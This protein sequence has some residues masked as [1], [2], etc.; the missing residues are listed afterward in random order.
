MK[1]ILDLIVV[2]EKPYNEYQ[3]GSN[4]TL[5]KEELHEEN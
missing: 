2:Q 3:H 5:A 1:P 4:L